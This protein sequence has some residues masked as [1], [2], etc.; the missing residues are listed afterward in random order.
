M[1]KRNIT[2]GSIC[3]SC[4][5]LLTGCGMV[6]GLEDIRGYVEEQLDGIGARQQDVC[7][8]QVEVAHLSNG[9]YVYQ[10]LPKETQYVYDEV[11]D[12]IL[13][14]KESVNVSTLELDVLD[15]AYQSVM[16]DYGELFWVSGYTHTQYTLEDAVVGVEFAPMY[17]KTEEETKALW[18]DVNA[19]VEEILSGIEM[20]ASDYEKARYV[21]DYLASNIAY[22]ADSEEN[23]NILSVFLNGATV[24]QGYACATQYLL[25]KLGIE[26]AIISGT[27][28]GGQHA[29]NLVRLDGDYYY[30]DTTWG[31]ASY[32]W[33]GDET[34]EKAHA[35]NYSYFAVT[36]EELLR[37]HTPDDAIRLPECTATADN[38][39]VRE[40]LYFDTWDEDAVGAV[41]SDAYE[42]GKEDVS[43]KFGSEELYS[44]AFEWFITGQHILDYCRE[45]TSIYYLEDT[46]KAV[47]TVR[48][49]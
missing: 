26:S 21:Y 41:F 37:T 38:Y 36:T 30:I 18:T 17:T 24:C 40:N 48:F 11:Y 31:N 49:A 27:A 44:Q 19:K 43:I 25:G 12:A 16:A 33:E 45:L 22:E 7:S 39:F 46:E 34:A 5:L 8:E 9:K 1:K 35:V 29:W 3:L 14:H 47:L 4:M 10:T 28:D 23:Q 20:T 6:S 32:G 15:Q 2:A 42:Q 13:H